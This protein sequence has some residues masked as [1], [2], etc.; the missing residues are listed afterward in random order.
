MTCIMTADGIEYTE[1]CMCSVTS[2]FW[3]EFS[4]QFALSAS[5]TAF[6][7]GYGEKNGGTFQ[8]SSFFAMT[9]LPN[10]NPP[11][12]SDVLAMIVHRKG[13]GIYIHL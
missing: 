7:L 12:V 10:L 5:G 3:E 4:R 2:A 11:R 1:R 8:S 13:Q 6:Y 9:E